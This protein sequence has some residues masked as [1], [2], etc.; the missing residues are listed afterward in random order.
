MGGCDIYDLL[1]PEHEPQVNLLGTHSESRKLADIKTNSY[2]TTL[3]QHPSP[4]AFWS[5]LQSA[6]TILDDVCP[7]ASAW[8][9]AK[10]D[11]GQLKWETDFTGCY[12]RYNYF[13]KVL[14]VNHCLYFETNGKR[15]TILAHEYRH[16]LQNGSKVVK[17]VMTI[18]ITGN[19]KEQ[20]VESDAMLFENKVYLA[21]Y[22]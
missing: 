4:E 21:I 13:D 3:G 2:E 19:L 8:V 20:I 12:A 18:L 10:H 5:D 17:Q 15:A 7:E 9:R 22:D 6:L 1:C 11:L 16:S 14:T